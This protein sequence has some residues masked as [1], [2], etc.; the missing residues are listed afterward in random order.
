[1]KNRPD[2]DPATY[3]WDEQTSGLIDWFLSTELPVKPFRLRSGVEV[4]DPL[5][6]YASLKSDIEQGVDGARARTGALQEDL[7][8]L[9]DRFG[10]AEDSGDS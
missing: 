10:T 1:M 2:D 9:F 8:C 5:R 3:S 4:A 6:F 7:E